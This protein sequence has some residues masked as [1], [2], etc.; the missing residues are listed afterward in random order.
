MKLNYIKV[1]I[2]LLVVLLGVFLYTSRNDGPREDAIT[3]LA[4]RYALAA[5]Q[6][7]ALEFT[8]A[9]NGTAKVNRAT[10][11]WE[12]TVPGHYPADPGSVATFLTNLL[13]IQP[14]RILPPD[15]IA[16]SKLTEYGLDQPL[17]SV[18]LTGEGGKVLLNLEI[19]QPTSTGASYFARVKQDGAILT[20]PTVPLEALLKQGPNEF[21]S[22]QVLQLEPADITTIQVSYPREGGRGYTLRRGQEGWSVVDPFQYRGKERLMDA[23]LV[24]LED[25]K[26]DAF[27]DTPVTEA[28]TNPALGLAV[29]EVVLTLTSN[30]GERQTLALGDPK[31]LEG[32][33]A[34]VT[35]IPQVVMVQQH[36]TDKLLWQDKDVKEDRLV[37]FAADAIGSIEARLREADNL[38]LEKTAAG[39][40]RSK[41]TSAELA[42][43]EVAPLLAAILALAPAEFIDPAQAATLDQEELGQSEYSL[44]L[45]LQKADT[46]KSQVLTVGKLHRTKGYYVWDSNTPGIF[47]L[48]EDQ[49][50]HLL[51]VI[52][53]VRGGDAPKAEQAAWSAE[54]RRLADEAAEK[55][56]DEAKKNKKKRKTT[57]KK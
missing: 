54:Q 5:D 45:E 8:T 23:T 36:I 42:Q 1:F 22:R 52:G 35:G 7:Q 46:F 41:P 15:E 53:E 28:A 27:L 16:P 55:A 29:P 6:V 49:V 56:A 14:D 32:V 47:L 31:P 21:R 43:K 37:V 10:N 11:G 3:P 19:G 50:S 12:L 18:L 17:H 57:A 33:Y 24:H 39:W 4:D 2:P 38:A 40:R 48:P 9:D 13:A 44:K 20:L 26:V 30:G 34:T 51:N 25:L